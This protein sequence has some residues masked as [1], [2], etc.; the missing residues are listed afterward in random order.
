M[1]EI[2]YEV[3]LDDAGLEWLRVRIT[4]TGGQVMT[5]AV[6]Y[7]TTIDEHWAPVVR[8]DNAHG[9]AHRDVI[10]I[11]GRVVKEPLVGFPT[12]KIALDIGDRDIRANWRRYRRN[13]LRGRDA[14]RG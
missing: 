13:Y 1:P 12:P 3:Q 4:T 6:Q 10:D 9:F 14:R 11:Q 2:D 5:F 8:Y 7:E